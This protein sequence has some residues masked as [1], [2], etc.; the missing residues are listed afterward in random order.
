MKTLLT[1]FRLNQTAFIWII[2]IVMFAVL[3]A[4]L[5]YKRD[6]RTPNYNVVNQDTIYKSVLTR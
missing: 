1:L 3:I 4:A 6:N 2:A 5:P